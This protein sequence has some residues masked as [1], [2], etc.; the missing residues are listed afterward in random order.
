MKSNPQSEKVKKMM[1]SMGWTAGKGLGK[2]EQGI[3]N[4]LVAK[5]FEG[6]GNTGVIVESSIKNPDLLDHSKKV[7]EKESD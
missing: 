5:K 6:G 1:A 3:V 2:D 4:P 7:E